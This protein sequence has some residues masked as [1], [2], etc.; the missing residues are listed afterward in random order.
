LK[1]EIKKLQDD[2]EKLKYLNYFL[3]KHY[4][5]KK[6]TSFVYDVERCFDNNLNQSQLLD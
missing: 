4:M 2:K 1:K 6:Y 3:G 5:C